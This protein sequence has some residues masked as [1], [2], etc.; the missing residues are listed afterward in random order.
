MPI[1]REQFCRAL[2]K[3]DIEP[4]EGLPFY[5]AAELRALPELRVVKG[6]WSAVRFWR[7]HALVAD[8]DDSISIIVG[9]SQRGISRS[10]EARTSDRPMSEEGGGGREGG[11]WGGGV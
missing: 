5:A 7:N 2:L 11:G 10:V 3:V 6:T 1:W 9:A 8:G 4:K